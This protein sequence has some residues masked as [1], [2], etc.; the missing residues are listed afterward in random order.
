MELPPNVS[1]EVLQTNSIPDD[2]N[3]SKSKRRKSKSKQTSA[4]GID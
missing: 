4:G 3:A 1:T 2:A